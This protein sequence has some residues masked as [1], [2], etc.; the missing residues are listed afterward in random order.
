MRN[1]D[2]TDWMLDRALQMTFP[3]S[4]PIGVYMPD[5]E[6]GADGTDRAARAVE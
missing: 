5:N 2:R 3:A 6:I 4:D 1:D